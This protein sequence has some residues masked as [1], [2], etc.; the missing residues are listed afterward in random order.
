MKR[1]TL[2]KIQTW[3]DVSAVGASVALAIDSAVS[4]NLPAMGGWICTAIWAVSAGMAHGDVRFW[5]KR[6][7]EELANNVEREKME[8]K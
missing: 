2:D 7:F 8:K 1:N 3:C 4:R 5:R 6:Y